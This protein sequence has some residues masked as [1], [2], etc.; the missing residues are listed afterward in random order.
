MKM[1][2]YGNPGLAAILAIA[3]ITLLAACKTGGHNDNTSLTAANSGLTTFKSLLS[4]GDTSNH[5]G[6][7]FT[8]GEVADAQLGDKIKIY[9]IRFDSV[10][11]AHPGEGQSALFDVHQDIYPIF[12]KTK[13]K[14]LTSETVQLN[15]GT[16]KWEVAGFGDR[17]TIASYET[18]SKLVPFA[19]APY[20]VRIPSLSLN[21]MGGELNNKPNLSYLGARAL[22]P[23][24]IDSVSPGTPLVMDDVLMRLKSSANKTVLFP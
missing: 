13:T 2:F 21:F 4:K 22:F 5:F 19:G 18:F 20:L 6:A 8:A 12:N 3:V 23:Q 9:Y 16:N 11:Y 14:I 17:A 7:P 15:T 1:K 10:R 24:S